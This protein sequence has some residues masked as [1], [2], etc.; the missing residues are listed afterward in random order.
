MQQEHTKKHTLDS[1][2]EDNIGDDHESNK[3]HEDEIEGDYDSTA[4]QVEGQRITAFNMKEEMEEGHFDRDGHFIWK[5]EK[6]IRDNWLDNIDWQKISKSKGKYNLDDDEANLQ[7]SSSSD[8][9]DSPRKNFDELT[10][11]K[12]IIKYMKPKET[13]NKTLKRLGGSNMKLSSVE[14]LK[15]K[16]AG[17]LQTNIDVTNMTELVNNILTYMGNMNVYQET[18]EEIQNKIDK[19]SNKNNGNAPKEMELDMYADDFDVKEKEKLQQ[20]A[21]NPSTSSST[22]DTNQELM[23]EF[24][25]NPDGNIQGPFSTSQMIKWSQDSHFKKGVLVRKCGENTNFYSSNRI[26]FELYE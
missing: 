24:K 17:T 18:Y 10:T 11:Y 16:K 15:R 6:E 26:D 25:W 23:W 7:S 5:N 22:S 20:G 12:E 2:E 13:I 21:N 9:D 4:R 3:L 19:N 1:D 14:R 8:E